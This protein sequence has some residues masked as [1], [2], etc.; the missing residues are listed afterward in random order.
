MMKRGGLIER[1]AAADTAMPP[2]PV[3][4]APAH[5]LDD[6]ARRLR[7]TIDNTARKIAEDDAEGREAAAVVGDIADG[8]T[9]SDQLPTI[10]LHPLRTSVAASVKREPR[11]G[12]VMAPTILASALVVVALLMSA[13]IADFSRVRGLGWLSDTPRPK[14]AARALS[15]TDTLTASLDAGLGTSTSSGMTASEPL[16]LSLSEMALLEQCETMIARGDMQ[17]ARLELANAAS[18]GSPVARFA[19]AETFD[20]NMLAA[21]GLRDRVADVG[22]ARALYAQALKA[23]VARAAQRI[24]ALEAERP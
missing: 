10:L 23:G 19:L 4:V 12:Q 2:T 24:S 21:W 9:R 8:G 13:S 18:A 16:Q 6:I 5:L 15:S 3:V 17:G 7:E 20:P 11:Q 14:L 1:L 22:T